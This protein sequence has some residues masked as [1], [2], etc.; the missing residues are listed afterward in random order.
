MHRLRLHRPWG[1]LATLSF[2]GSCDCSGFPDSQTCSLFP[3]LKKAPCDCSYSCWWV[4]PFLQSSTAVKKH[5]ETQSS[6]F[7]APE[8][9]HLIIG[10][11][12]YNRNETEE[13]FG[14]W[15]KPPLKCSLHQNFISRHFQFQ[16]FGFGPFPDRSGK[17]FQNQPSKELSYSSF[18]LANNT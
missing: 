8:Q 14:V 9:P 3:V 13:E 6:L 11:T 10:V 12:G 15:L 7:T 1:V 17:D 4:T 5:S 18:K 2:P 16:S